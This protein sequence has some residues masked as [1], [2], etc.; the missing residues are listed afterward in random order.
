MVSHRIPGYK[1]NDYRTLTDWDIM[2]CMPPLKA[3][4]P[5]EFHIR[6][7]ATVNAQLRQIA[8]AEVRTVNNVV[9]LAVTEWLRS[10]ATLPQPRGSG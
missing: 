2:G 8:Q 10:R 6:F 4:A 5:G 1:G 7:P 9:L 3:T